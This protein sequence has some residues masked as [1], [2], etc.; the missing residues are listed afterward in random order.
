MKKLLL[1]ICLYFI[2][3]AI[4]E[5]DST[6]HCG[7]SDMDT[8]EFKQLPWFDNNDLLEDFLGKVWIAAKLSK[9]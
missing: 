6:D 5:Q 9:K 7:T 3:I 2:S 8:T 4:R 1:L